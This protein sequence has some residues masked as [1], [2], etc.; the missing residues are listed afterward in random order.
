MRNIETFENYTNRENLMEAFGNSKVVDINNKPLLM[1]HGGSY[2]G[3][4]AKGDMWFTTSKEDA[5]YYA[6]Q[7]DGFITRAYLKVE[8]PLY[9]GDI[10]HLNIK[11]TPNILKSCD[12][13]NITIE[14]DNKGIIQYIETN[15]ATLIAKD[16]GCDGVIDLHDG[17]ILDVV[18]FNNDQILL[19]N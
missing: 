5:N 12:K 7:S 8:S 18:V 14:T 16:I 10:K 15:N 13:R 1:Y 9:S 6:K 4:N 19:L 11:I 3:S 2:N 17:E